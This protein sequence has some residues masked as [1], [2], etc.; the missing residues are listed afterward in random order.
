M[1]QIVT[2]IL[3]SLIAWQAM[4]QKNAT[5][6][7][8]VKQTH[9]YAIK[10]ADSLYLDHYIA[11]VEGVRPCVIFVFGGGFVRGTRDID[12]DIPYFHFLT[13]NGYDVVSIDYRLGMKGVDSPGVV[14]FLKL[15]DNT[16]NIAVEDLFSATNFILDHADEWQ[17]NKEQIVVSGSS[18]GAITSL[19][20]EYAIC[21]N[22]AV[23]KHLKEGFNYAGVI[24]F[25]GAVFTL[26]GAPKWE[27]PTAPMLL[28]H[29]SSDTQVPYRKVSMFGMGMYGSKYIADKLQKADKPYWL[30]TVEYDTH[31]MAG[32]PMHF[33]QKEILIF[34]DEYVA[35]KRHLQRNTL[36]FDKD[37]PK[38]KTHF[39]PTDFINSNYK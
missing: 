6:T 7:A 28:F 1:K 14:E 25:A 31:S 36:S 33:N 3:A 30:Y 15:F 2:I 10:G 29:G 23:K 27:N 16:I 37:I 24:S 11:P 12:R 18:A 34:L 21:N 5:T 9:L 19:Q 39:L 17:I 32:K 38:A 4:A 13:R 26:D 22:L 35:Q 20:A 8:P